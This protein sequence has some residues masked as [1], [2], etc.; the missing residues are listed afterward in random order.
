M[1]KP[2]LKEFTGDP[3]AT[4]INNRGTYIA[5]AL[6]ICRAY[7]VAGRPDKKKRLASF[8]GWSDTV[9]SAIAWLGLPDPVELDGQGEGRRPG[10]QPLV[11]LLDAWSNIFGTGYSHRVTLHDVITKI[12]QVT[13]GGNAFAHNASFTNPD[14]R[15]AVLG[16]L[17]QRQPTVKSLG[18]WLRGK[19]DRR[20][21]G[22]WFANETH[23]HGSFWWVM[24]SD[25]HELEPAM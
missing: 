7:I 3:I 6:T 4:V 8:E 24:R 10:D 2:E 12:E 15:N 22:M 13:S 9:R 16:A 23:T 14:L 17:N 25:G 5:A 21:S 18:L 11:A 19:K 20:V 1:E